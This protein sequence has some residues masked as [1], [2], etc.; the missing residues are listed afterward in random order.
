MFDRTFA[1]G[2]RRKKEKGRGKKK[3]NVRGSGWCQKNG[4]IYDKKKKQNS[5]G[6]QV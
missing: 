6:L 2:V 1:G 5:G 3:D 4:L